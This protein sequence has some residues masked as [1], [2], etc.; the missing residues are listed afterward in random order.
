MCVVC[1]G[2]FCDENLELIL[3]IHELRREL[4]FGS[5]GVVPLLGSLPRLSIAGRLGAIFCGAE[6]ADDAGTGA[7]G[8]AARWTIG[9]LPWLGVVVGWPSS[10]GSPPWEDVLGGASL[11]SPGD[12]GACVRW[13]WSKTP[14]TSVRP[15]AHIS[16]RWSRGWSA[17][18]KR[19]Y[20]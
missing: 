4:P 16:F 20:L 19:I 2:G 13:W 8:E 17:Q 12:D 9:A 6:V 11:V 14:A 7:G 5:G 15:F 1:A 10:E 18:R 3:E